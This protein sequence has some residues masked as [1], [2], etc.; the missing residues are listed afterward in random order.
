MSSWGS[1]GSGNGQFNVPGHIALDSTGNLYVADIFNNRVQEFGSNG[2][3]LTS[4]GTTGSGN[5]Q[6][7]YPNGLA[8]DSPSNVYQPDTRNPSGNSNTRVD[9]FSPA[10]TRLPPSPR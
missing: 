3:F 8:V 1:E 2:T 6:L 10:T 7:V 4:F 5:G 9:A